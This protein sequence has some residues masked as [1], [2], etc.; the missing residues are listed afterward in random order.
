MGRITAITAACCTAALLLAAPLAAQ[1]ADRLTYVTFSGPVSV[2]G[3]TLPAGTYAFRLALAR[4]PEKKELAVLMKT[5]RQ[6]HANF[7]ADKKAAEDL[8]SIGELPRPKDMDI[9]D[10]A[11]MTGVANVLLNLNETM[12]K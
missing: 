8:L 2:P 5:Y 12:T 10:L 4:P 9:V 6:Q 3:T 1:P 11:A 7:S